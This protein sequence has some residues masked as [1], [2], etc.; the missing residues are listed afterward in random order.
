MLLIYRG[1]PTKICSSKNS[2]L[3]WKLSYRA[4]AF[5]GKDSLLPVC[6]FFI[7]QRD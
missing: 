3:S 5:R 6:L 7:L 1:G 4:S 2:I